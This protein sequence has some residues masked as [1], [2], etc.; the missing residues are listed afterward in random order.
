MIKLFSCSRKKNKLEEQS[1]L[2]DAKE[3]PEN[4]A[5]AEIS[6]VDGSPV[7]DSETQL[8]GKKRARIDDSSSNVSRPRIAK[9]LKKT[10]G[11]VETEFET[12]DFVAVYTEEAPFWLAQLNEGSENCI[13]SLYTNSACQ[14]CP[15][16]PAAIIALALSGLKCAQTS[17]IRISLAGM[18]C[19]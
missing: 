8:K 2:I 1:T 3:R 18:I 5:E 12:G 10:E 17:R 15:Y 9:T 19:F 11:N 7:V 14:M 13:S 16:R 6:E 4:A